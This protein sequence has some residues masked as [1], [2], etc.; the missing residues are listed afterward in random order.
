VIADE[1]PIS[2][3]ILSRKLEQLQAEIY[4]GAVAESGTDIHELECMRLSVAQHLITNLLQSGKADAL[5]PQSAEEG[6]VRRTAFK[7]IIHASPYRDIQ[8]QHIDDV[9]RGE[10]SYYPATKGDVDTDLRLVLFG[11]KAPESASAKRALQLWNDKPG[12]E[13]MECVPFSTVQMAY[14]EMKFIGPTASDPQFRELGSFIERIAPHMNKR[15][16]VAR[17]LMNLMCMGVRVNE[18]GEPER[19]YKGRTFDQYAPDLNRFIAELDKAHY[20]LA[21]LKS[22]SKS[23]V[24]QGLWAMLNTP[25]FGSRASVASASKDAIRVQEVQLE[26][27]MQEYTAVPWPIRPEEADMLVKGLLSRYLGGGERMRQRLE[28]VFRNYVSTELSN[29]SRNHFLYSSTDRL[30][31]LWRDAERMHASLKS[32]SDPEA[33][34]KLADTL[35]RFIG[36]LRTI[37]RTNR[38]LESSLRELRL[39]ANALE[40]DGEAPRVEKYVEVLRLLSTAARCRSDLLCQLRDAYGELRKLR[41]L[42]SDRLL[43]G[44][45]STRYGIVRLFSELSEANFRKET[46]LLKE[47]ESVCLALMR[48]SR[49]AGKLNHIITRIR[50]YRQHMQGLGGDASSAKALGK[51]ELMRVKDRVGSDSAQRAA[52]EL[53]K[54]RI[55]PLFKQYFDFTDERGS[56]HTQYR[57]VLQRP[58]YAKHFWLAPENL[59]EYLALRIQ[60]D[61]QR[62]S[63]RIYVGGRP[64]LAL[65]AEVAEHITALAKADDAILAALMDFSEKNGSCMPLE[66]ALE[67]TTYY[68]RKTN[69][70]RDEYPSKRHYGPVNEGFLHVFADVSED[71][72]GVTVRVNR[73]VISGS[74]QAPSA[75][76]ISSGNILEEPLSEVRLDREEMRSTFNREHFTKKSA[77]DVTLGVRIGN[78]PKK[79]M[80]YVHEMRKGVVYRAS[81]VHSLR[82]RQAAMHL[83]DASFNR[84]LSGAIALEGEPGK[85]EIYLK[86]PMILSTESTLAV[87]AD[88]V[89]PSTLPKVQNELS[90][91]YHEEVRAAQVRALFTSLHAELPDWLMM[92]L[93]EANA[94]N[95]KSI[96]AGSPY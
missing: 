26:K 43:G 57:Q 40:A 45:A 3:F 13:K 51:D 14:A 32:A 92:G 65:E 36:Q 77:D 42:D 75:Q 18:H 2:H 7:M 16:E 72:Q 62:G 64:L 5:L 27:A 80:R 11:V 34:L 95:M 20:E 24:P 88:S 90:R 68:S 71:A 39:S 47:V 49:D 73:A 67:Y 19:G 22:I 93:S 74:R 1:G 58:Y 60:F 35:S 15:E 84:A 8:D 86:Q 59:A 41:E 29:L 4:T 21:Y 33:G 12:P 52:Y 61:K 83:A 38:E 6:T 87:L 63:S 66:K 89:H 76:E 78:D 53:A 69:V 9:L 70:L 31:E 44:F 91:T 28:N 17:S 94:R 79:L 54:K 81:L 46:D 48:R 56:S 10:I 82:T 23:L 37:G 85:G 50:E 96:G 55:S 30:A 25:I